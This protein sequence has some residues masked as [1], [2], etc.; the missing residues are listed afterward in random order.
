MNDSSKNSELSPAVSYLSKQLDEAHEFM[1]KV[2]SH[3][4]VEC[5]EPLVQLEEVLSG[6]EI[7]VEFSRKPHALGRTRLYLLREGQISSFLKVTAEMNRRGW[8]MRVEDGYRDCIMQKF[9]GLDPSVFDAVLQMVIRELEGEIPTPEHMFKRALTLVAQI[10]KT[11]THMSGSALD[12]SVLDQS[13]GLEIDRGAH[14]LEISEL[15]P[16][17]S[18]FISSTARKNRQE[19]T[20]IMRGA[21]FV[22]YPY[23]F[24]HYSSG[25]AY[26]GILCN[27]STPAIYGAVDYD[28]DTGQTKSIPNPELSLNDLDEI[29]KEIDAA[30]VRIETVDN[31]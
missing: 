2:M 23:E 22:E 18:P 31:Q 19:I 5:G 16:M 6:S 29:K 20:R 17:D 1:M 7:H 24:W 25:D 11:G 12:I 4:V 8:V 3:P 15:T 28:S 10:P 14:Y 21:G 26:E 9:I 13:T 27:Q 30:I